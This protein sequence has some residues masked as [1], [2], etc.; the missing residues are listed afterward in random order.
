MGT[1][2]FLYGIIEVCGI[3]YLY[4]LDNFCD[5]VAFMLKSK[6]SIIWKI[7]WGIITPT[8]LIVNCPLILFFSRFDL[9]FFNLAD[10]FCLWKCFVNSRTNNSKRNSFMG[11][12]NWLGS[13]YASEK[14][15]NLFCL[16]KNVI[17]T[18]G[19]ALF[20]IP[21]WFVITV[22][23]QEKNCSSIKEVRNSQMKTSKN[24]TKF[25]FA[26]IISCIAAYQRLGPSRW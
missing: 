18:A 16:Y 7:T 26:E 21:L 4:G 15:L 2:A 8:V 22:L 13:R 10:Y 3:V 19:I 6:V 25:E 5:D 17:F 24:K 23:R 9:Q 14:I 20:Q 11:I 12:S 1:A